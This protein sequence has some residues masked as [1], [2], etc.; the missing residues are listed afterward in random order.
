M[1]N[2][3]WLDAPASLVKTSADPVGQG[4]TETSNQH[5]VLGSES[6]TGGMPNY[7]SAVVAGRTVYLAGHGA[8]RDAEGNVIGRGD[9]EIQATAAFERMNKTLAA[10]GAS[11]E[12]IVKMTVFTTR[13][14]LRSKVREV[15]QRYISQP[16]PASTSV[17]I[18]GLAHPD[19]LVEIEAVA[20]IP[21]ERPATT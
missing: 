10:A 19:M 5:I 9:I 6:K 7:S 13:A 15:R 8:G 14:E 12:D 1:E 2:I 11:F 20:V 21:R 4:E 17:V 18:A 3:P 16:P